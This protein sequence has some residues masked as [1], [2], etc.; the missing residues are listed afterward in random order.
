MACNPP[1]HDV[2]LMIATYTYTYTYTSR[3]TPLHFR[4]ADSY[5]YI[6]SIHTIRSYP[7]YIAWQYIPPATTCSTD[8]T[9]A[10]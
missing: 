10:Y 7:H 5:Y 1:P 8:A 3:D 6:Y 2:V 4:P 9:T